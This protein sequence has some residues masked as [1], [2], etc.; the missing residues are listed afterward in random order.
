LPTFTF[1]AAIEND[2]AR[3][4]NLGFVGSD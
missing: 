1:E 2:D 4:N 3:G